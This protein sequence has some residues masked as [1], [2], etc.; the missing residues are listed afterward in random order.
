M[1]ERQKWNELIKITNNRLRDQGWENVTQF[2]RDSNI[3][4]TLETVRRAFSPLSDKV[5]SPDVLATVLFK[6]NYT[7]AEVK[8][9]LETYTDQ[10]KK[11]RCLWPRIAEN[12]LELNSDQEAILRATDKLMTAGPALRTKIAESLSLLAFAS[13]VDITSELRQLQRKQKKGGNHDGDL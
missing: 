3:G 8:E 11:D 1:D 4:Y 5:I 7:A 2:T 10:S 13:G 6:L 12:G 9:L